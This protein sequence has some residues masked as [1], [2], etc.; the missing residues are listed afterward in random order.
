[1]KILTK[2]FVLLSMVV[3]IGCSNQFVHKA[4]LDGLD[5]K[6]IL[7]E[8]IESA[9]EFKGT[10]YE[11]VEHT[12]ENGLTVL[13]VEKPT[14]PVVSVQVWYKVGS[15]NETDGFKGMAHL[16]EHMMFRGSDNFGPQEHARLIEEAGGR[17]Q[18]YTTDEVTVYHQKVPADKLALVLR[19][20]ADRMD[21]LKLNQDILDTER[22]LVEE[23]YRL[24]VDNNPIGSMG[25][26]V[27]R[28]LFP[29][30]P[31]EFG[32][33]GR[34]DDIAGFS[35]EDCRG[36]F[37]SFYAPNN[38]VLI[39]AGDV[40]ADQ[41]IELVESEFGSIVARSVD[42]GPELSLETSRVDLRKKT[43]TQLPIPVTVV[44]LYTTGERDEDS[45]VLKLIIN[46]LVKGRSSRLWRTLVREKKLA[47]YFV[48][49]HIQGQENGVVLFACAHLPFLSGKVKSAILG[50]LEKIK[51]DGLEESE[52]VK[53]R[54]RLSSQMMFQR[55]YVD[56]LARGIG[57]SEVVRG[58]YR[59]FYQMAEKIEAVT[60]ANIIRV[61]NKYFT[62]DNVRVIYFEPKEGIFLAGL[63]GFI[64][65][66]FY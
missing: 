22:E 7:L 19:L 45:I 41:V 26:N 16:F 9:A 5:S 55:Y 46:S 28:F 14:M 1:M 12:L 42:P 2:I 62:K 29:K 52:F 34:M 21:S 64:K 60:Q 61:A 3:L 36:F 23:E 65:S 30:H 43:Q 11:I 47:E 63:A 49:E 54:N 4:E 18:A 48:G 8:Q 13:I 31:Y 32:P 24:R 27:R 37:E 53:A 10:Q 17:F 25:R 35:V 6:E 44:A 15:A 51:A 59:L 58:D 20:E 38:A 56:P 66:I 33:I 40:R 50:E 39:V 57:Y